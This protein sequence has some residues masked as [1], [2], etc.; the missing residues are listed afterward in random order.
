M[1]LVKTITKQTQ[2]ITEEGP[3]PGP[4]AHF[5]LLKDKAGNEY[6]VATDSN[7]ATVINEIKETIDSV[8]ESL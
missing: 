2:I 4:I 5:L 8:T 3:I 6:Q 7:T 1:E